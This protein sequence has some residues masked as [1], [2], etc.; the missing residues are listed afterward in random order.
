MQ[1]FALALPLIAALGV[2]WAWFG[3]H[4][5]GFDSF[6][7]ANRTIGFWAAVIAF[8]V[9]W[10]WANT[11]IIGPQKAY[12]SG[13]AAV[14]WFAAL[15]CVGLFVFAV[16][17]WQMNRVADPSVPTLTGYIRERFGGDMVWVYTIVILGTSV[18]AVVGQL[19]GALVLLNYAT[20]FSKVALIIGLAPMM[21]LIAY[22]RGVESSFAADMVKAFM[23]VIVLGVIAFVMEAAGKDVFVHTIQGIAQKPV[24]IWDPKLLRMFV[25]PLAISWIAGGALDHQLYQR[26]RSLAPSAKSAPWYGILPFGVVVLFISSVGFFAPW[27]VMQG[28]DHQLAGFVAIQ[29]WFPVMGQVFIITVAAA[30]L[31][32]GASALNASA[33]TWAVDI[34]RPLKP[35]WSPLSVSRVAMAL[36]LILSVGLALSGVTLIQLVLFIGSFRGALLFP[37]LLGLFTKRRLEPSRLFALSIAMA[38]CTGPAVA[39]FTGDN[40]WGGVTALVLSAVA[41]VF[42]WRR[43]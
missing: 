13:F 22:P 14:L 28:L 11:F 9:C 27:D 29:H 39:Y 34:V 19:I 26:S 30:L 42:E 37:T 21:L 35:G 24:D 8:P 41:C 40:L 3:R 20:G 18:Y 43:R 4:K 15:N 6:F 12:E 33:S 1:S 7:A 2:A 16:C 17:A 36:I 5:A 32:T 31:A 10:T 38:M 23:I 25:L